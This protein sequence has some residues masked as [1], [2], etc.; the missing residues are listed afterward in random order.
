MYLP[1]VPSPASLGFF[2]PNQAFDRGIYGLVG[3]LGQDVLTDL[4]NSV[5]SAVNNAAG[6]LSAPV[7]LSPV[8]LLGGIAAIG[9][10]LFLIGGR[11]I[12][13]ARAAEASRLRK[14]ISALQ[15]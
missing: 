12:P 1:G 13:A 11:A 8:V 2:R 9:L 6:S 7:T 5:S 14:R 15:A 3:E 4:S 10:A